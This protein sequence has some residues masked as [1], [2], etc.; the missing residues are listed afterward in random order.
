MFGI[1]RERSSQR[2]DQ[3]GAEGKCGEGTTH[4]SNATALPLSFAFVNK[5]YL[6]S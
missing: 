6:T 5:K 3:E 4:V 2:S 1:N